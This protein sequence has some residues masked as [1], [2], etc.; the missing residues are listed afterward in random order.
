MSPEDRIVSELADA[1]CKRIVRQTR[2]ALTKM[3]DCR[4]S[5]DDS[6]LKNSWEEICVQCQDEN[7]IF[8]SA[9]EDTIRKFV[10]MFMQKLQRFEIEAVWLQT[11]ALYDDMTDEE[12]DRMQ[13]AE[14]RPAI[15]EASVED[16][17]IQN[18]IYS[19][20]GDWTNKRIRK[21]IDRDYAD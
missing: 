11:T 10:R 15:N 13:A 18:Y 8:C 12:F 7:S 5:G 21:F 9:Y 6:P 2:M 20:A 19:L 17:I 14:E 16:H 4:L 1:V 3:T